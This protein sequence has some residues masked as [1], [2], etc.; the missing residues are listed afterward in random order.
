MF[1]HSYDVII[2]GESLASRVAAVR[3]AK[4]GYRILTFRNEHSALPNWLFSS[5]Q[6]E[7]LLE[8]LDGRSCY[9]SADPFQVFTPRVRIEF[10][11]RMPLKEEL[12]RELPA[13]HGQVRQV[14]ENLTT[15]GERL[16]E[17]LRKNARALLTPVGRGILNLRRTIHRIGLGPLNR[18]LKP[19]LEEHVPDQDGLTALGTLFSGMSLTAASELTIAEAALLWHCSTRPSGISPSGLDDLLQHRYDQFHG[20]TEKLDA[21][22]NIICEKNGIS[23]IALKRGGG[24]AASCYLFSDERALGMLSDP[25][26]RSEKH[27]ILQR[28]AAPLN[29]QLSPLLAKRVIVSGDPPMRLALGRRNGE[30]ACSIELNSNPPHAG[31]PD[32]RLR[33]RLTDVFPFAEYVLEE[34]TATDPPRVNSRSSRL[35]GLTQTP[36]L[37]RNSWLCSGAMLLPSLGSC[38]ETLVGEALAQEV[39]KRVKS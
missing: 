20:N 32:D 24:C 10:N 37:S 25:N 34:T 4:Q 13:S 9:T 23:G 15:G 3:L 18:P 19:Y 16:E 2:I 5:L 11:G 6:L 28:V 21:V 38:G 29:D 33:R 22:K 31:D 35:L 14:L 12:R 17:L 7:S 27:G 1:Q 26:R 36:R 30:I 8:T 39:A